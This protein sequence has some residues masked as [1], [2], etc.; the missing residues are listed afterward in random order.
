MKMK[1]IALAL[2]IAGASASYAVAGDGHG[3]GNASEST[4]TS[5]STPT[6]EQHGKGKDASRACKPNVAFVLNGT[7]VSAGADGSFTMKV[8]HANHHAR[9]LGA[10]VTV[11]TDAKTRI[12]KNGKNVTVADLKADDRLNVQARGCKN[13]PAG[14]TQ[15]LVARRVVA[16]PAKTGGDDGGETTTTT[17]VTTTTTP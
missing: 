6:T 8:T 1:A 3:N 4:T 14:T 16:H 2:F 13:P 7:F 9:G 10:T 5:T 11:G 17:A 12:R 15:T